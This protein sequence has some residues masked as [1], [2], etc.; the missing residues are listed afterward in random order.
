MGLGNIVDD[1]D[2]QSGK[3]NSGGNET[4]WGQK[5]EGVYEGHIELTFTFPTNIKADEDEEA[6]RELAKRVPIYRDHFRDNTALIVRDPQAHLAKVFNHE[7][8]ELDLEQ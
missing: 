7:G 8:E 1:D 2:G 3:D 6:I 4:E 5:D